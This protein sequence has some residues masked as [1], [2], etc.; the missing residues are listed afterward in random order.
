VHIAAAAKRFFKHRNP[1]SNRMKAG[2]IAGT[3]NAKGQRVIRVQGR[4][5]KAHLLAHLYMLGE[6]PSGTLIPKDWNRD[7]NAWSNLE[8]R[9]HQQQA[10][11]M[12]EH[13][14]NATGYRGVTYNRRRNKYEAY[15]KENGKRRR[16]GRY[17][18]AQDASSAYEAEA[19]RVRGPDYGPPM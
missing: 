9:T 19:Q 7:N 8:P 17:D 2:D 14:T 15:I 5:Y 6:W 11:H 4:L 13:Q 10:W 3:I 12:R 18:T 1:Q 16:I